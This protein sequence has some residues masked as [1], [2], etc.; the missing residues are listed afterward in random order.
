MNYD[1]IE[2]NINYVKAGDTILHNNE[3]KTLTWQ[4][5]KYNEFMGLSI[6]GDNYQ[7]GHKKVKVVMFKEVKNV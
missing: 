6:F 2:K 5:I 1:I 4:N 7:C 3:L